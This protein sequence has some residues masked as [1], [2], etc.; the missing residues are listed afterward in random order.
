M[1]WLSEMAYLIGCF[2]LYIHAISKF[3]MLTISCNV[4]F[5]QGRGKWDLGLIFVS[6]DMVMVIA[7]IYYLEGPLIK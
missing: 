1:Y 2:N 7:D 3:A 4:H 6:L 5:M